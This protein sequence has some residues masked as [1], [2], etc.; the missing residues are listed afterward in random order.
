MTDMQWHG[1]SALMMNAISANQIVEFERLRLEAFSN[2]SVV[3]K[4]G[5]VYEANAFGHAYCAMGSTDMMARLMQA[6]SKWQ[7]D[8]YIALAEECGNTVLTRWSKGGLRSDKGGWLHSRTSTDNEGPGGSL[9]QALIAAR[10]MAASAQRFEK[11][12]KASLATKHRAG[13]QALVDQLADR[14]A[15]PN[16]SSFVVMKRGRPVARSWLAYGVNFK[17]RGL[18]FLDDKLEKNGNYALKSIDILANLHEML[19]FDMAKTRAFKFG[20]PAVNICELSLKTYRLKERDGWYVDSKS[21][22]G[23][24]FSGLSEERTPPPPVAPWLKAFLKTWA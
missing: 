7:R 11:A 4:D 21:S 5:M 16:W 15:W 3:R 10:N 24:N 20:K 1:Y 14:D 17:D 13:A 23:G 19:G 6:W 18:Y 22:G 2:P 8:E 9:N 12:G